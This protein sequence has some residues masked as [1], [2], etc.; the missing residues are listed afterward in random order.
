M[1]KECG[2]TEIFLKLLKICTFRNCYN[3]VVF[4]LFPSIGNLKKGSANIFF[5]SSLCGV[6]HG[7]AIL[8]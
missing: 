2:K 4:F 1:T 7:T 3:V 5:S 6:H 8:Q